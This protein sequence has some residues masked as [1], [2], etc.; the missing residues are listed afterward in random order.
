MR[1]GPAAITR[2]GIA[3]AYDLRLNSKWVKVLGNGMF[4]PGAFDVCTSKRAAKE[5][6]KREVRVTCSTGAA[7]IEA[8]AL[9]GALL[10]S[11]AASHAPDSLQNQICKPAAIGH[12]LSLPAAFW[13]PCKWSSRWS[14]VG[15]PCH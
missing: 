14:W 1:Q 4:P 15:V 13:N 10:P 6:A 11:P 5:Q 7:R 8:T 12:A 3:D 2:F 9:E